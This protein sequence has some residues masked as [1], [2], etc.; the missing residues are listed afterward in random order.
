MMAL[1]FCSLKL[2][3]ETMWQKFC[4]VYCHT[5]PC[6]KSVQY[7]DQLNTLIFPKIFST[8]DI[9][10]LVDHTLIDHTACTNGPQIWNFLKKFNFV[11]P[12]LSVENH[13]NCR[14]L[15]ILTPI[16]GS[17]EPHSQRISHFLVSISPNLKV[18]HSLTFFGSPDHFWLDLWAKNPDNIVFFQI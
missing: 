10:T 18:F 9:L 12:G 14:F 17:K 1:H 8:G 15:Q 5:D 13:E 11:R 7:L 4:V 3:A 6:A 16:F 2:K